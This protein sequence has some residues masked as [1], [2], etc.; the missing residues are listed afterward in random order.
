MNSAGLRRS[1]PPP[2]TQSQKM[3]CSRLNSNM[4][5]EPAVKV[6]NQKRVSRRLI[7]TRENPPQKVAV[8]IKCS[9]DRG[10]G[11][12][13][14]SQN[15]NHARCL[16]AVFF[17]L[18]GFLL[19]REKIISKMTDSYEKRAKM[20]SGCISRER[21]VLTSSFLPKEMRCQ[22]ARLKRQPVSPPGIQA[23]VI[24]AAPWKLIIVQY[25]T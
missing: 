2:A 18:T 21:Q 9:L 6:A 11:K 8:K 16:P 15:K 12:T 7:I 19:L 14:N 5:N 20:I 22:T 10:K 23:P 3:I 24:R 25:A 1:P 17:L 13:R 4:T